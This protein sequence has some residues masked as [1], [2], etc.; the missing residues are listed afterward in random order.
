[1]DFPLPRT[2]LSRDLCYGD[3]ERSEAVQNNNTNLELNNLTVE[4]ARHQALTRQ[5]HA[6]HLS[7]DAASAVVSA[8]SSPQRTAP[9]P[10]ALRY[11]L[12]HLR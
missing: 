6:M 7:F 5:F 3:A 11:V 9:T 8:P 4:V 12:R 10:A 2:D 1:M